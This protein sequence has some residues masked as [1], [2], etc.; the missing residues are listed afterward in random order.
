[1]AQ[2]ITHRYRPA[3][4]ALVG[5]L[6]ATLLALTFACSGGGGHG[7]P[8]GPDPLPGNPL[9][10]PEQPGPGPEQPGPGP[11]Q[12]GP[13]PEQPGPTPQQ[14]AGIQGTY[15]LTQINNSQPGQLVTIANPDGIVVGLYRFDGATTLTLDPLQTFT[16]ELRYSD[17]KSA[18]GFDD[19]GEFK[20]PGAVEGTLALTFYSDDYGDQFS[21]I[22]VDG[23][24]AIQYD[25]D[26]DGQTETTF[27][28]T[29]IN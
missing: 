1:M 16:L 3:W 5:A 29:R 7:G 10:G 13:G 15:V 11:E 25:F 8:T 22:A 4:R 20:S 2:R 26:G 21:G 23:T 24:V 28:F 27:G 17:D 18:F 9:P 12:P 6:E 14:P 19:H